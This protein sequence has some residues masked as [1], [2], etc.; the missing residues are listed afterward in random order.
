[1]RIFR[2]QGSEGL[3]TGTPAFGSRQPQEESAETGRGASAVEMRLVIAS[4]VFLLAPTQTGPTCGRLKT[5]EQQGSPLYTFLRGGLTDVGFC[6]SIV[7]CV[8]AD[9]CR[10]VHLG[11]VAKPLNPHFMSNHL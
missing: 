1:M 4:E 3:C 9:T 11:V 7:V 8:S 10:S 5:R 2:V 6:I